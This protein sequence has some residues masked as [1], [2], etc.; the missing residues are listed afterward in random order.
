MVNWYGEI[1]FETEH[2]K[3]SISHNEI[4]VICTKILLFKEKCTICN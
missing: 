1:L 4:R 2:N 3:K